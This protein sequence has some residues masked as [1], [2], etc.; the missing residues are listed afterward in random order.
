[1]IVGYVTGTEKT[2]PYEFTIRIK[3]KPD[4]VPDA[5]LKIGDIVKTSFYYPGHGK[6]TIYAAITESS[7]SWD[8]DY[9]TGF[10]ETMMVEKNLRLKLKTFSARAV[11]T[12]IVSER[13]PYSPPD[14]PPVPGS[15]VHLV[16]E[17]KEVQTALGTDELAKK[18]RALPVGILPNGAVMHL[19][20]DYIL[21][22]NG[23]H[24]NISGQSGVAAKTSCMTFLMRSIIDHVRE[25]KPIFIVFNVKG[26]SLM[27]LD[28][29]SAS[30]NKLKN[31]E[32]GRKWLEMYEKM[33]LKAA[34]FE[35]VRFYAIRKDYL[36]SKPDSLRPDATSYWW[37]SSEV[38]ELDLFEMIFDPDELSRNSN[39]MLG[40]ILIGEYMEGR[41]KEKIKDPYDLIKHLK[42]K[43]SDL[44][45]FL[46]ED[47]GIHRSTVKLLQ[48]R[49]QLAAK[50]GLS[51][52]WHKDDNEQNKIEWNRPGGITVIDISKLRTRMQSLV[53]GGVLRQI[54]REKEKGNL[55][56]VPV[57]ILIDELNKY[58]PRNEK[59]EIAAIFRDVAE[60]GRSFGIILIGAEQTASEVDYRVVTQASTTV[61]GRQ[62]W[63]ELQK[64]EYGHLLQQQRKKAATLK[65]GE[66]IIDQ[67]FLRVPMMVKFPYPAWALREDDVWHETQEIDS[68]LV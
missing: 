31:T 52:L 68:Y 5:M 14:V 62:K 18:G 22:N 38:F 13:D 9:M 43:D 7:A 12:R 20:L 21:G 34:P 24:I 46:I 25:P 11:T 64:S 16:T 29:E 65:Q 40:V 17:E 49:I 54:L 35:N 26:Q 51:L 53:V 42:E 4:G 63:V 32:R 61:V 6:V 2:S 37:N 39:L 57:F 15:E 48:R 1:M 30:W 47:G 67:P 60:R 45:R 50:S 58:S 23:A 56:K 19:D 36:N 28:R 59:S 44:N 10:E 55:M 27:F 41:R 33:E 66:V 8:A 3:S